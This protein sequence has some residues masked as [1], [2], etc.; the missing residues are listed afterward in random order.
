MRYFLLQDDGRRAS[1]AQKGARPPGP[2]FAK[3][4]ENKVVVEGKQNSLYLFKGF[5]LSSKTLSLWNNFCNNMVKV[6][7]NVLLWN[8]KDFLKSIINE[9]CCSLFEAL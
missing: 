6:L 2:T 5:I 9:E 7:Q 1:R 3:P 8:K 4:A